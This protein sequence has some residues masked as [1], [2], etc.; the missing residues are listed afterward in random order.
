MHWVSN[1]IN[2]IDYYNGRY[3]FFIDESELKRLII[4]QLDD[5]LF[6]LCLHK[7]KN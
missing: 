6:Y 2:V 3:A 4:I 7:F 1:K 5:T